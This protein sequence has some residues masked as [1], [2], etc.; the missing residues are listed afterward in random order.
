MDDYITKPIIM[1][2]LSEKLATHCTPRPLERSLPLSH[3]TPHLNPR[4]NPPANPRPVQ[5]SSGLAVQSVQSV[6]TISRDLARSPTTPVPP[7]LASLVR[8]SGLR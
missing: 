4:P 5:A 2:V 3:P 6:A 1:P 8:P 7:A